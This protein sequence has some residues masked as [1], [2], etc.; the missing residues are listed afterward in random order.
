MRRVVSSVLRK[1]P[2]SGFSVPFF[3]PFS[4]VRAASRAASMSVRSCSSS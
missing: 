1:V 2:L 3:V 4:A